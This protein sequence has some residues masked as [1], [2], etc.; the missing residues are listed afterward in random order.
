MP[1]KFHNHSKPNANANATHDDNGV[2]KTYRI[3]HDPSSSANAPRCHAGDLALR[4]GV[5]CRQLKDS[6]PRTL[7]DPDVVRDVIIGLSDGLTVP[8]A[9]TAG[10][11]GVGSTRLVVIAGLAEL[12]SGAISMG[13]GGFLSAQAE[14]QHYKFMV[15]RIRERVSPLIAIDE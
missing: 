13:I 8:F 3:T 1:P 10:L 5:C 7:V 15:Q 12:V 2:L 4:G 6:D 11:S 14:L 9:L